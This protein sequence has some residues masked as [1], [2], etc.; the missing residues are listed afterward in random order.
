MEGIINGMREFTTK[1]SQM[2]LPASVQELYLYNSTSVVL[3]WAEKL[4]EY[5]LKGVSCCYKSDV[6]KR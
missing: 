2:I 6:S 5:N 3:N 1:M 4:C